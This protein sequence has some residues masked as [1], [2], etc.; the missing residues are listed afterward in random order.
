MNPA[1]RTHLILS[2]L[3]DGAHVLI[4]TGFTIYQLTVVNMSPLQLV[5]VGSVL[6][7]TILL[8]E[9]PTGVIADLISRR[10]SIMLGFTLTGGAYLLQAL[11]P[12][13]PIAVLGAV[14]WGVGITCVS[15]AYDAWLA[16]ELGQEHL[17]SALLRGEQVARVAALCGLAGS[18]ILGSIALGL[19]VLVGGCLF[20]IGAAYCLIAMPETHF[21]RAVDDERTTWHRMATTLRDG[22]RLVRRRPYLLR[23]L[24]V[25]FFFGLFSEAW[26][27]LWQSHL[28]LTFDLA[29]LTPIAP[30]V[31]L[32]ALIGIE[33]LLSIAAA[34][35]LRRRL[36][37]D[38][39]RQ[40][41]RLVFGFTAVMVAG[42]LIYGLAPHI[43]IAV[44]AFLGFSVARGLI[45]P[46]LSTWQNAQIDDS[47]VRATVL[48]LGGQSDA[49]GQL[50]GGLPLGAI[51]NRSLRAA[52][53][54]SAILLVPNLWLLRG[55]PTLAAVP[56]LE[57]A[58]LV[59]GSTTN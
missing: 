6:E 28:V 47:R 12:T 13:F 45:G 10:L 14:I 30:I 9:V 42:L 54:T 17:G 15:G 57:A 18:A 8:C 41:Q 16:D 11:V 38:D 26:D 46:L 24:A 44:I 3:I 55:R 19:P 48:S 56:V 1:Y 29:A 27:R 34:E 49:L 35:V 52:F 20:I 32:A 50:A 21:R 39:Q 33:M 5:L 4:W 53:V 22:V 59:D 36:R 31:L 58:E 23:L 25:L 43:G 2:F 51:G 7:I 37:S 40:T